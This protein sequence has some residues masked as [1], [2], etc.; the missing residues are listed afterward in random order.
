MSIVHTHLHTQNAS[1]SILEPSSAVFLVGLMTSEEFFRGP[2]PLAGNTG[3][4]SVST[5]SL[6]KTG[7]R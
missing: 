4:G 5:S 7:K 3:K 2:L 1:L 6:A